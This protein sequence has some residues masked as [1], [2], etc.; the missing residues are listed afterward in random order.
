MVCLLVCLFLK[1]RVKKMT[2]LV[3]KNGQAGVNKATVTIVFDNSK[4]SPVGY[5]HLQELS[6][7]RQIQIGGRNKYMINGRNAKQKQVELLEA[8]IG[9][10]AYNV[11]PHWRY[12][13][14]CL[15]WEP[16]SDHAGSRFAAGSQL[17]HAM[18][19]HTV[20]KEEETLLQKNITLDLYRP[21][22]NA[23]RH[24]AG[25]LRA[26]CG[27]NAQQSCVPVTALSTR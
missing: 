2:Q 26:Q 27:S 6:V 3:Y 22:S 20:I 10:A 25:C 7:A 23:P 8:V 14:A 18:G 19:T 9:G 21:P 15:E 16:G 11:S 5:E 1:V 24:A 12:R 13:R 4:N 17:R